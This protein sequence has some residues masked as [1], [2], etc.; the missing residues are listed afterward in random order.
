MEFRIGGLWST[1]WLV[2]LT[3]GLCAQAGTQAQ[4]A[5]APQGSQPQPTFR[6]QIDLVTTDVIPRDEKENF[7]ADLSKSEFEIFEDGVKQ[8][9]T[10]M[11]VS[12][13][14]RV[15]NILAPPPVLA[16]EGLVLPPRRA[17]D[18]VAGRPSVFFFFSL[19]FSF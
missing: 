5:P 9:I 7:I 4:P 15:S 19:S 13:G 3:A 10:S 11:T 18:H 8:E 16:S 14:G 6:V 2:V 1:A 17:P 12:H